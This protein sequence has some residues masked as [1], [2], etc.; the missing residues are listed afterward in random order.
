MWLFLH[1]NSIKSLFLDLIALVVYRI[2][3]EFGKRITSINSK[4]GFKI[5]FRL[6]I[7]LREL[8]L[9]GLAYELFVHL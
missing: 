9:P 6:T 5:K 8:F 1:S 3:V 2:K 7:L 4:K